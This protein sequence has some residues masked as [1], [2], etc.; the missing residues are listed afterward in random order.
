M[1]SSCYLCG[2]NIDEGNRHEEH[3]IQNAIGGKLKSKDILCIKCGEKCGKNIDKPFTDIFSVIVERMNTRKDRNTKG[4]IIS[5]DYIVSE[6]EKFE[7]SFKDFKV[8]PKTP[9]YKYDKAS[10]IAY[11]YSNKKT[12]KHFQKKVENEIGKENISDYKIIDDLTGLIHYPFMLENDKLFLG[13]AKIATG[14]AIYKGISRNDLPRTFNI[15]GKSIQYTKNIV[16]Y[17]PLGDLERILEITKIEIDDNYPS[18]VL[19]LFTEDYT[20]LYGD[21]I[22]LKKRYL[23]CY[24]ELFSTFQFYVILNDDYKGSKVH[25][26]YIQTVLKQNREEIE[27]DYPLGLKEIYTLASDLNITMDSLKNKDFDEI[28]N[29]F[30]KKLSENPP[31]E[32]DLYT[33]LDNMIQRLSIPLMILANIN[34]IKVK[35]LLSKNAELATIVSDILGEL[36]EYDIKSI[37]FNINNIFYAKGSDGVSILIPEIFRRFYCN[38]RNGEEKSGYYITELPVFYKKHTDVI[39]KYCHM[40]FYRLSGFI[41]KHIAEHKYNGL[42]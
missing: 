19:I 26:H 34:Q 11:L 37:F 28:K 42:K 40:K 10:K 30:E 33:Y 6:Q 22:E 13:L 17:F 39:K 18:H 24:I 1:M 2:Q 25:K 9:F 20:H 35:E 31:Y 36:S 27:I 15:T 8:S 21:G 16:A 7:I 29:I 32:K 3:I 38:I 41:E 12:A 23:V 14:F 5:G 4:N